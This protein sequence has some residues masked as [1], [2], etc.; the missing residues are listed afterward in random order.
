[1]K[2]P[3]VVLTSLLVGVTLA[4]PAFAHEAGQWIVRGGVGTVM[5]KDDNLSL[6][7]FDLVDPTV[8]LDLTVTNGVVQV[9]DGT[10]LTLSFTYMFTENWAFDV[11]AAWPFKHDVDI[12]GTLTDN[13][14]K[15]SGPFSLPFGEVEHLPP[16]FS[17]Q[18][19]FAPDAEFQPFV[20]VGVNYTT[21]LSEDLDSIWPPL[22]ITDFSLDDSFGLALQV[23]ADWMFSD[24]W[25]VN[26]DVRWISIES[27]L[28]VTIDTFG[29][30]VSGELGGVKIDP[31]VFAINLGYRF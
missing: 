22:T 20:G 31:W 6:G 5:P 17:V 29:G 3:I 4:A 19:H 13:L 1:M 16:T 11:L 8:P 7:T 18:Y 25:L 9:D 14:T 27:D 10:S 15:E 26:F 24:Q 23:G 2:R 28:S 21:F 30:P 12:E